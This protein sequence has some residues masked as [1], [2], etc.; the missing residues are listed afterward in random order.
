MI[1][2]IGTKATVEAYAAAVSK[3]L[4][5]PRRGTPIGGGRHVP[6]CDT[7]GPGWTTAWATVR[8][9]PTD[10]GRRS[11]PA[12]D[13]KDIPA[14]AGETAAAVVAAAWSTAGPLSEDWE[15]PHGPPENQR[16]KVTP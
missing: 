13:V 11:C 15:P 5:L 6:D 8:Q 14:G 16:G 3:V 7:P 1:H 12:L 10:P 2:V 4:G 9:H